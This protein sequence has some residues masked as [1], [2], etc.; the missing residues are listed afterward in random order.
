MAGPLSGAHPQLRLAVRASPGAA[1]DRIGGTRALA[2]GSLALVVAVTAVADR[3]RANEAICRLL[4]RRLDIAPGRFA[5]QRGAA[6]RL[7]IFAIDTISP[8][9]AAALQARVQALATAA[10]GEP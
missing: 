5:L 3:G 1:A 10:T 8:Q 9:E 2:D 7:K 4:A 6:N